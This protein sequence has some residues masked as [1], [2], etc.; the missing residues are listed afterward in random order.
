MRTLGSP[1]G[2]G[3]VEVGIRD[4][5]PVIEQD[6]DVVEQDLAFA[7]QDHLELIGVGNGGVGEVDG[8]GDLDAGPGGAL[9]FVAGGPGI[10]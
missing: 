2:E 8:A 5:V 4:E 9:G 1:A 10:G 3:G 7:E 6:F